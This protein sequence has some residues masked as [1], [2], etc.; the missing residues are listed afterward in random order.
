MKTLLAGSA[1]GAAIL[2]AV[3]PM[4]FA[5]SMSVG[6]DLNTSGSLVQYST[7][8]T[9]TFAGPINLNLTDNT[10]NYTRLGLRDTVGTQFTNTPQWNAAGS[11]NFVDGKGSNGQIVPLHCGCRGSPAECDPRR[12]QR[13]GVVDPFGLRRGIHQPGGRR[14][15]YAEHLTKAR[16]GDPSGVEED[17]DQ[18]CSA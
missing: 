12:M 15:L 8:S 10:S 4:A 3:A 9:H 13:N 16:L 2:F 6:G 14:R 17:V 1:L 18:N 7:Y 5:D 11:Q